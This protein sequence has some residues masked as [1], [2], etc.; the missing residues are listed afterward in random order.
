[1]IGADVC[2]RGRVGACG[3]PYT[4]VYALEALENLKFVSVL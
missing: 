1:M 2:T 3:H 4:A